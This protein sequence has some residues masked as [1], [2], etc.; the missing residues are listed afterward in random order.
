[1]RDSLEKGLDGAFWLGLILALGAVAHGHLGGA[2]DPGPRMEC[3]GECIHIQVKGLEKADGIYSVVSSTRLGEF[4]GML[5]KSPTTPW[6]NV[7]LEDWT[8]LQF[9]DPEG[10]KAPKIGPVRESVKYLLGHPMDL[11]RAGV[12][13]LML[14]PGIGPGLAR[15]VVQE[16]RARGPFQSP[17][18][19]SRVR[20]FPRKTLEKLKGLV[21]AQG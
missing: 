16:R 21:G 2:G 10:K 6:E 12:R 7:F 4:L 14:L 8:C 9:L 20:S 1:M 3:R 19:L 13:D 11:N 15:K 5:G 18:D 17:E